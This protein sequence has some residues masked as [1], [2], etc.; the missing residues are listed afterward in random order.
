MLVGIALLALIGSGVAA[1][2]YARR[3]AAPLSTTTTQS[4]AS[5][6][7][8]PSVIEVASDKPAV[9]EAIRSAF[10]G[11]VASTRSV[12]ATASASP[13]TSVTPTPI[14]QIAALGTPEQ[15][16]QL[17]KQLEE[18]LNAGRATRHEVGLL[19]FV[20][21][22]LGDATCTAK[23]VQQQAAHGGTP[24]VPTSIPPVP[25]WYDPDD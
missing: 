23:A 8:V 3:P 1:T 7:P 24:G 25:P 4:S 6:A 22:Q 15:K 10:V 5:V 11:P 18:K 9:P 12:P 16:I 14:D 19:I 2:F 21:G 17:K 20:C 13:S